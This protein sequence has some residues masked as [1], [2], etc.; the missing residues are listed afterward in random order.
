MDSFD[1]EFQSEGLGKPLRPTSLAKLHNILR[2]D[3]ELK[4]VF[5][6]NT[7]TGDVEHSQDNILLSPT[8]KLGTTI[9]D[10]DMASLR[11]YLTRKYN[12]S[13]SRGNVEDAVI[14]VALCNQYH[15]IKDYLESVRWDGVARLD[16]WLTDILGA[17]DTSFYRAAGRKIFVAAVKRIYNPGCYFAQL[18]IIEGMQRIGKSRL[19]KEMGG[20]WYA[21]IHL[22][23]QDSK[24]IVEDMRGKW[25]LEI[26]EMAGFSRQ[27]VE[28]MKAFISRQTDRVR[29]AYARHANDYPRQS[30]M[31]ATMNP[32]GAE[33]KY[34]NDQTGNVRYWPIAC[35]D[36]KKIKIDQF[37][38]LRDQYFA[39]AMV[40]YQKGEPLWLDTEEQEQVA[41][42]QQE[43]R[44]A[45]DPWGPD[46]LEW[47]E[48]RMKGLASGGVVVR[49]IAREALKLPASAHHSGAWR[50]ISRVLIKAGWSRQRR[51]VGAREWE[52]LPPAPQDAD[53]GPEAAPS[54][55]L[56]APLPAA[57]EALSAA[58]EAPEGEEWSE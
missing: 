28:Y 24:S 50:R 56:E 25:I 46:I 10:I 33:N 23:T 2:C 37:I 26:E 58:P 53:W 16:T 1:R 13:P 11:N 12:L 18:P 54:A 34:L 15:P 17:A 20:E 47:S 55:A 7:F 31:I 51:T 6:F 27:E 32:D 19:L 48:H 44:L 39:E 49:E 40:L 3:S 5:C 41:E 45:E 9:A 38:D 57:P 42:V 8:A 29:A 21:S 4:N 52:Y 43:L 36:N 30:V 14:D 35:A 22:K